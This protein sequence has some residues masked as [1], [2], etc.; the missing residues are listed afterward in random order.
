MGD[1]QRPTEGDSRLRGADLHMALLMPL[2]LTVSC[3]SKI[4]L[5]GFTLYTA[6][7]V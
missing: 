4:Q 3:L 7:C 6:L 2:P 5:I 1:G